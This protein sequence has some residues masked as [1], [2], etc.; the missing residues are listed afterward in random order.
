[1]A[2]VSVRFQESPT[3]MSRCSYHVFLSFRG[4]DTRKTFT[5]HLHTAMMFAGFHTFRDDD[6]LE[7]GEDIEL[8]LDKA[9][10]ESK[11][12]VII[13]SKDYASSR[14]CLDE[15]LKILERKKTVGHIILPVFYHVHPSEVRNQ[16]GSFATAFTRHE[17]HF[18]AEIGERK[19]EGMA[20]IERWKAAL[21]EVGDLEGEVL[22]D[23]HESQFIQHIVR[24]IGRK[25]NRIALNVPRYQIA[26]D[27]H[28]KDINLWLQDESNDVGT[29]MICGMA[30]IG[31]TTIAKTVYNLNFERFHGSCSFLADVREAAGKPNG[32]ISLQKQLIS[33][34]MKGRKA[35]IGCVD[36]GITMIRDL[37]CRKRVLVVL[38]DVDD[39]DQLNAFGIMRDWF[40]PG[41]KIM[42]TTRCE[43]LLKTHKLYKAH[44]VTKL[45]KYESL[46]LFSLHAFEQK[47][48]KEG[49][50]EL[51][52]RVVHYCDGV[53]LALEVLGGCLF[54]RKVEVWESTLRKLEA[55]PNSVIAKKLKIS[56]ETLEDEHDKA[57]FLDI[58]C[59]F[60]GKSK[61]YASTIL[62]G[63]DFY[64]E[65]GIRNLVDRCLLTID[66]SNKLIMHQILKDM[67]RE[68]VRQ[69]SPSDLGKRSRLWWAKDSIDVLTEKT[70][71]E[72]I[73]GLALNWTDEDIPVESLFTVKKSK[74]RNSGDAADK[75]RVVDGNNAVKRRRLG[76]LSWLPLN[77]ALSESSS[78]PC[79]VVLRTD[80]FT[81]MHKLRLLQLSNIQLTGAFEEF[82][83]RLRWLYWRGSTFKSIPSAFPM[84]SLIALDMRN[85]SLQQFWKG[86]KLLELLKI[87]NLSHS[88]GLIGTPNFSQIPNLERLILKSCINLSE[89][90]ESIGVL[91]RLVLLNLRGCRNL[92]KL[93]RRIC[94]LK[95]LE[96]LI[97]SGCSRLDELPTGLRTMK[98][99]K[100]L[101]AD[102]TAIAQVT[103]TPSEVKP[104]GFVFWSSISKPRKCPNPINFSLASLSQSLT[105]L[106]LS[107]CNLSDSAIP[108]DFGSLSMLRKLNVSTNPFCSLPESIK[109]LSRLQSIAQGSNHFRSFQQP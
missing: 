27:S 84:E 67:G 16:T 69:E 25:L 10:Q 31:K 63:C 85:S 7:I 18:K 90:H 60:V 65:V 13:F 58:A 44:K 37:I 45:S 82:P 21:R 89:V 77:H 43:Q 26:L 68:I 29:M 1:M 109:G 76:L 52:E 54:G 9:I 11:V 19:K 39:V 102:G 36:E 74:R 28:V 20:K 106:S 33:N 91:G 94:L 93:P 6:E 83:K 5:D 92:R 32:L 103:S 53:P 87:L 62:D 70:G 97:V 95:R 4:K 108:E 48:P 64:A 2:A 81:R 42:I 22:E 99:L 71:T 12:S 79:D 50:L 30:G 72:T 49:Y 38:D 56:Y 98:S 75:W 61:T 59:F 47:Y 34:I 51:S 3:L 40:H 80:M 86:T 14:W 100:L 96:E 55:I 23:R 15:L 88:Q 73:E 41:S 107:N 8:G 78:T 17:E 24:V 57:L 105:N 101:H 46:I 104:W 66:E 35:K